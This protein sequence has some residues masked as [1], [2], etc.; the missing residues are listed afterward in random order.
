[1]TGGHSPNSAGPAAILTM[2]LQEYIVLTEHL[3][4]MV[5]PDWLDIDALDSTVEAAVKAEVGKQ[6]IQGKRKG[7]LPLSIQRVDI[8]FEME[9]DSEI[10]RTW[11]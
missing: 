10:Q 2:G 1:M 6:A 3:Y 4:S 5:M 8:D 7:K 9:F 11:H